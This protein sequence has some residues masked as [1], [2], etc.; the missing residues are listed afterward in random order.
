MSASI[1]LI[2]KIGSLTGLTKLN[3]K[4]NVVKG[5]NTLEVYNSDLP[6]VPLSDLQ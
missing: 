2:E 1:N 4:I 3:L 6:L 5:V